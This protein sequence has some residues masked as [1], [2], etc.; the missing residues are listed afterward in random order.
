MNRRP[1][2]TLSSIGPMNGASTA[3]G[4]I[5]MSSASAILVRA[6]SSEA[7]KNNVP[8]SATVTKASPML[9]AAVSSMRLES[10][11]RPAPDAPVSRCRTRP[12]PPAAEAPARAADCEAE[13]TERVARLARVLVPDS[14][15]A[16]VFCL[17]RA[18]TTRLA[19]RVTCSPGLSPHA[20]HLIR[21]NH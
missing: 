15:I 4:A 20:C 11:V 14:R 16:Q 13:T 1:C 12:A 7:L 9:L 19:R 18:T 5:V 10:P 2:C 3:K 17:T 8:A 21:N 6:W